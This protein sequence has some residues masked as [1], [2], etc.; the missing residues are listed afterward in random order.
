MYAEFNCIAGEEL[1]EVT[2]E[3]LDGKL[4][5]FELR[6]GYEI[7]FVVFLLFGFLFELDIHQEVNEIRLGKQYKVEFYYEPE[8][9]I[10]YCLA[11]YIK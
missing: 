4:K 5:L 8:T 3:A 6:S 11:G 7:F 1:N 10:V 2:K 9:E